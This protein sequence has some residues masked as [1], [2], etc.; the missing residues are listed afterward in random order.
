MRLSRLATAIL[1]VAL[2][3]GLAPAAPGG[4]GPAPAVRLTTGGIDALIAARW[5]DEGLTPS[6][7]CSDGD[8]LRRVSLDLTGTLPSL[9]RTRAFLADTGTGKRGRVVEELLRSDDFVEHWA[10][11]LELA[12]L[13]RK[14]RNERLRRQHFEQWIRERL[15]ANAPYDAMVREMMLASGDEREDGATGYLLR[16]GQKASDAAGAA[17]RH[18][19]GVQIQCAQCHDHPYEAWKQEDFGAFAGFFG[20]TGI[21]RIQVDVP[22]SAKQPAKKRTVAWEVVDNGGR[23]GQGTQAPGMD[24]GMGGAMGGGDAAPEKDPS[25]MTKRER[26]LYERRTKA[27]E[28]RQT[29]AEKKLAALKEKN[30]ERFEQLEYA[31]TAPRVLGDQEPTALSDAGR[32]DTFATW[33]TADANPWF[34]QMMVNRLW[35]ELFGRGFVNPVDDFSP[36]NPASHPALLEALASEFRAGGYDLRAILRLM[37]STRVYQLSSM[38]SEDNAAD[39]EYFARG[40]TRQLTAEQAFASIFQATLAGDPAE[41]PAQRRAAVRKLRESFLEQFIIGLETD[42]GASS[43]SF[44]GSIP[45]ALMMLNSELSNVGATARLEAPAPAGRGR[46]MRDDRTGRP[47]A[48]GGGVRTTVAMVLGERGGT[49][50][51]LTS[52]YL[53]ALVREPTAAELARCT[54]YID[55]RDKPIDAYEDVLWALLN[56]TEFLVQ[57]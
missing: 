4:E 39:T 11:V 15:K 2:G 6:A 29:Q 33:L 40:Y 46:R 52:L 24:G 32:R 17:S 7:V 49:E 57:R 43:D 18:F 10:D 23:Y 8:F 21:R 5:K 37:I 13:G 3:L 25:E 38:P 34:A 16:W 1:T 22:A 35:S 41:L 53:A 56:S 50:Q 27:R 51:R 26:R 55:G 36:R 45:Q 28:A 12:W 20:Q 44:Q 31:R 42:D 47:S 14:T 9:E 19:L 54:T 48:R 30:P